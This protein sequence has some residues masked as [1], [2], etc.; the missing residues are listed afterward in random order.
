MVKLHEIR[1]PLLLSFVGLA[2]VL[3]AVFATFVTRPQKAARAATGGVLILDTTVTN[4]VGSL[5]AQAAQAL[6]LTVNVVDAATWGSMTTANFASYS[7]IILGD[8]TCVGAAFPLAAAEANTSVWGPAITGNVILIGTDPVFHAPSQIGAQTLIKNGVAFATS[9]PGST[10]AYIDLSCY[11]GGVASGTL[12]PVLNGIASGFSVVGQAAASG[13]GGCPINSHIVG[14]SPV[15]AGLTDANLSNW[16]CSTHEGFS[17]W[18][19]NF[20]VLVITE[21]IPSSFVAPDGTSGAPYILVRGSSKRQLFVLLQGLSSL[22]T[23]DQILDD[24]HPTFDD[25]AGIHPLFQR[26]GLCRNPHSLE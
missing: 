20:Q 1:R 19:S 26:R 2:V 11:Y 7:A 24:K 3:T 13:V 12:V 8:P 10:G 5:E 17:T 16:F 18:P 14:N 25:A 15:L 22:L 23:I 21:D 9:T 4:G 6:G